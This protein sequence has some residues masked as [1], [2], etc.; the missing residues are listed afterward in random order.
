MT[1]ARQMLQLLLQRFRDD[2]PVF[3]PTVVTAAAF[4]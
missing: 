3:M 4:G 1:R 2:T